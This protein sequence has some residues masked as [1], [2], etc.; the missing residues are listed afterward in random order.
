MESQDPVSMQCS[1]LPRLTEPPPGYADSVRFQ[2][3]V[4]SGRAARLESAP[5]VPE[6]YTVIGIFSSVADR[7]PMERVVRIRHPS[8][9]FWQIWWETVKLRRVNYL[10][11]LKDVK[12]F[13]LYK[14][15]RIC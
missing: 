12:R 10:L 3:R 9:L 1:A 2:R 5:Q 8:L 13:E 4:D 14:V 15:S 7:W 11:S 6:P